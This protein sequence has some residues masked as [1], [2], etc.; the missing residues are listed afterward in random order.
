MAPRVRDRENLRDERLLGFC[1]CLAIGQ[2]LGR[3]PLL[4]ILV[5]T[6]ELGSG[7][8][9]VSDRELISVAARTSRDKVQ[10]MGAPTRVGLAEAVHPALYGAYW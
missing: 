9:G 4:E 1:V 10:M 7:S 2:V 8:Q 5:P 3:E 6:R